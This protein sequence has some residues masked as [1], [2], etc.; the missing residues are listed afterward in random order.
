MPPTSTDVTTPP[1][2]AAAPSTGLGTSGGMRKVALRGL[3]DHKGRL[4]STLLA[5]A[6]GVAFIAGVLM[7]T[8]TMNE[9]FD[10]L[11]A[12]AYEG[13]DAFVR[14]DQ[15]IDDGM[16]GEIRSR[17]DES[18]LD[19]VRDAPD[20]AEAEGSVQGYARIIDKDGDPIGDPAMGP[21]TFGGN[22][23][24]VDELNGFSLNEGRAP[25]G[26]GGV[27]IDQGS[28]DATDYQIGDRVPIQTRA[29]SDDFELVGIAGFGNADSPGG[30]TYAMWT[31]EEAQRLVG[32]PGKFDSV[33][34]VAEA[35]VSQTELAQALEDELGAA[36][37]TDLEVLTGEQI[38]EETQSDL[39]D[40]LSFI[41]IFLLIF[42]VVAL[43]VGTFV[44][45]NSFS[46]IVAQ[47][48]REMALMR[49]V[50]ASR[51]QVRRAVFVEALAIGL[52]GSAIGVLLGLGV[53]IL[54]VN[55]FDLPGSLVVR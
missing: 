17:L 37:D 25:D 42:A 41:T 4:V 26:P 2:P 7:L 10:D 46:I 16:G 12:T 38:T 27:V 44:I 35:G 24:E 20:V 15:T 18:V 9:S 19:D 33:S 3:M 1:P 53:A 14:A 11:F 43:I 54:L 22:W 5:V 45:Y 51:R 47:R 39:K 40:Q 48:G 36:G 29:G 28:A 13:T 23:N 30:A 52:A 31:T 34:A 55:L 21:P 32:E 50:G 6:L 8:D 49:A